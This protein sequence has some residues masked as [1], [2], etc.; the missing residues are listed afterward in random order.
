MLLTDRVRSYGAIIANTSRGAPR[1]RY[2]IAHELG[3]FLMDWHEGGDPDGFTCQAADMRLTGN[4]GRHMLQESEA[5]QFAIELLAPPRLVAPFLSEAPDLADAVAM[6]ADL[7]ISLEAAARRMIALRPER[8]ALVWSYKGQNGEQI[9]YVT[10]SPDFPWITCGIER[11][12]P[13]GSHASDFVGRGFDGISGLQ[14]GPSEIWI[15]RTGATLL[16]QT[17][18]GPSGYAVTLLWLPDSA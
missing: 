4:R 13:A 8:L 18:I 6:A 14:P 15:R 12:L 2:T 3:H 17:R 11:P 16:E 1:M 5:N 7:E 9:R 10:R